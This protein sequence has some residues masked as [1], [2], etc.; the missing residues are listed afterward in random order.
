MSAL[1]NDF[2]EST[3][4]RDELFSGLAHLKFDYVELVLSRLSWKRK[5]YPKETD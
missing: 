1:I 4:D 2:Q 5:L 3:S